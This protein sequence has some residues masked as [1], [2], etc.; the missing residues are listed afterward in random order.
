MNSSYSCWY[1]PGHWP[2]ET[3][4]ILCLILSICLIT[5]RIF[6][7]EYFAFSCLPLFCSWTKKA[8][9]SWYQNWFHIDGLKLPAIHQGKYISARPTPTLSAPVPTHFLP[10]RNMSASTHK[11]PSEPFLML[12]V[13]YW[14]PRWSV[15]ECKL[16]LIGNLRKQQR[17][18]PVMKT[19][20]FPFLIHIVVHWAVM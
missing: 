3:K 17:D 4:V 1:L 6:V 8:L 19:L 9:F 5:S 12:S 16:V 13:T 7:L 11:P 2:F 20:G 10:P 14:H 15:K 18:L